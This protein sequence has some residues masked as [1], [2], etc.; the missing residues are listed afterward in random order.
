MTLDDAMQP[1]G[2]LASGR[3]FR[4]G[5]LPTYAAAVFLLVLVWAG[6]PGRAVD[7]SQAWRTANQLGAVQA[8]LLA[9]AVTL[10]AVLLQP[11][12]LSIVRVLEGGFPSW[13]G[14]GLARKA[15]AWRKNRAKRAIQRKLDKAAPALDASAAPAAAAPAAAGTVGRI[16]R[17]E[18]L[19]LVQEA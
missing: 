3:F 14:S 1:P 18:A 11:L 17:D 4:V 5:Y 8:L 10:V 9:L 16:S 7:F 15:Q 2:A 19:K 12:Q 13:L 6:A